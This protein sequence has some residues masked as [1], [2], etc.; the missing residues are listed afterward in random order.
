[1][2]NPTEATANAGAAAQPASGLP[3]IAFRLV[4][5]AFA[6]LGLW[7]MWSALDMQYY[8]PVGPGPGYFPMWLGGGLALLSFAIL[9]TSFFGTPPALP[10]TIVP[11]RTPLMQMGVTF[12]SVAFFALFVERIG[13]VAT[14]FVVLIV[15]M[16]VN[17]VRLFPT[18]LLVALGGS[19]GVAYAFVQW[20]GV[21]LPATPFGLLSAIGL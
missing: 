12:A 2:S 3:L 7:V 19:L 4:S 1:M 20:L 5:L 11:G 15:L 16:L 14:M 9:G 6:A 13:F 18:A 10:A 21:F 17:R 8:T